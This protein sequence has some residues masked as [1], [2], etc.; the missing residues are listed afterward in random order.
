MDSAFLREYYTDS[1][2]LNSKL[3]MDELYEK[4]KR[5]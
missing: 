3:D 1:N 4:K 5:I 2:H